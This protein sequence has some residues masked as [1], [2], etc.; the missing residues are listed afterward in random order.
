[1]KVRR[2]SATELERPVSTRVQAALRRDR[3]LRRALNEAA[4]RPRSEVIIIEPEPNERLSTIRTALARI[5]QEEPRDLVWG[6]RRGTIVI[7]KDHLPPR[8]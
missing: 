6:V 7:S 1:M 2:A 5:L 8:R 3:Q 4:A